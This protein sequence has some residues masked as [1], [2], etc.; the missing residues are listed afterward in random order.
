[1]NFR[2]IA[3]DYDGTLAWHAVVTESTYASLKQF[4]QSGRKLLLVTGRELPEY[5]RRI[6]VHRG[7]IQLALFCDFFLL[8]SAVVMT[9]PVIEAAG[10]FNEHLGVGEDYEFFLRAARHSR[11]DCVD[12]T[13]DRACQRRASGPPKPRLPAPARERGPERRS[14]APRR[15]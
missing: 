7:D 2:A 9:R 12:K 6:G 15:S 10:R 1:M 4:K 14:L 5:V 8:T 11:A 3:T 13:P